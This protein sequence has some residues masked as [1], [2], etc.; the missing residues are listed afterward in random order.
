MSQFV[1]E[2]PRAP[3]SFQSSVVLE[4]IWLPYVLSQ[5]SQPFGWVDCSPGFLRCPDRPRP[6]P[7]QIFSFYQFSWTNINKCLWFARPVLEVAGQNKLWYRVFPPRHHWAGV[8][9]CT[10]RHSYYHQ[11]RCGL[12]AAEHKQGTEPTRG[13]RE[14]FW[15]RWSLKWGFKHDCTLV[16]KRRRKTEKKKRK[17]MGRASESKRTAEAKTWGRKALCI[18]RITGKWVW[19]R[20]DR[21]GWTQRE[22]PIHGKSY[23]PGWEDGILS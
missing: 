12:S 17:N 5:E 10:H 11:R 9:R 3:V 4:A 18:H 13:F 20:R 16:K 15:R 8:E 7:T 22:D 23:M 1:A 19:G 6:S 2:H 14:A 21:R